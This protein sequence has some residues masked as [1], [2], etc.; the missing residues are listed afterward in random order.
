MSP[1]K[2]LN[3]GKNMERDYST[4]DNNCY[5]VPYPL[6]FLTKTNLYLLDLEQ[7]GGVCHWN[8]MSELSILHP[9][10]KPKPVFPVNLH[11]CSL[12][13]REVG[14]GRWADIQVYEARLNCWRLCVN[15][16]PPIRRVLPFVYLT[17]AIWESFGNISS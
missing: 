1:P 4:P 8:S 14:K 15:Q 9:Y 5:L 10:V 6:A 3:N 7:D 17:I 11:T 12:S 16:V 2:H 13:V